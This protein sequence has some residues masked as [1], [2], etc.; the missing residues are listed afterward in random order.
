MTVADLLQP[1]QFGWTLMQD[2]SSSSMSNSRSARRWEENCCKQKWKREYGWAKHMCWLKRGGW[3]GR[4]REAGKGAA[5]AV[6]QPHQ[7]TGVLHSP[8]F[9]LNRS[10]CWSI[11]S[12]H[13]HKHNGQ[14]IKQSSTR[15]TLVSLHWTD[16]ETRRTMR[17]KCLFN[18][19]SSLRNRM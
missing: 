19:I 13:N 6:Q 17:V 11:L 10:K 2:V 14:I 18:E 12:E 7:L 8:S 16:F 9:I 5:N 15:V 1:S 4:G 3:R